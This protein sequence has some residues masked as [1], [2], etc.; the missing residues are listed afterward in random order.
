MFGADRPPFVRVSSDPLVRFDAETIKR[1]LRR[2]SL[3]NPFP[4]SRLR[5]LSEPDGL[6]TPTES[7][8]DGHQWGRPGR[9]HAPPFEFVAFPLLLWSRMDAGALRDGRCGERLRRHARVYP[10]AGLDRAADDEDLVRDGRAS[11]GDRQ[12][13]SPR[14]GRQLGVDGRQAA[15]P[16]RRRAGPRAGSRPAEVRRQGDAR[17]D[18]RPF[19]AD[20]A[21]Q[22]HVSGRI[23]A[24]VPAD[25]RH[26]HRRDLLVARRHGLVDVSDLGESAQR[27]SRS[28]PR[29]RSER[30]R[31]RGGRSP[32]PR[33]VPRRREEQGQGPA[34]QSA[35][36]EDEGRRRAR[37]GVPRSHRRRG[38]GRLRARGAARER[39]PL[40]RAAGPVDGDREERRRSR[41]V[42]SGERGRRRAPPPA[43]RVPPS[44]LAR[45]GHRAHGRRRLVGRPA[46][47]PGER[48]ALHG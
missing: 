5:F 3:K 10:S 22:R 25:H 44:G 11:A 20:E 16:R 45:G 4:P 36:A 24:G 13:R 7:I 38:P 28:S 1:G 41:D 40:P 47:V 34:S 30:R 8:G 9:F 39:L 23:G 6:T 19:G 21:G 17:A 33:V 43:G 42:R 12:D 26:A 2:L 18:R 35:R 29:A 31:R 48:L 46:L 14:D 15:H 27:R 32:L 37:Q